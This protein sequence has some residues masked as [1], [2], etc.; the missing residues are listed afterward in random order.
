M[1]DERLERR[2]T[3]ARDGDGEAW[4]ALLAELQPYLRVLA[5]GQLD[6]G[7]RRR[8]DA[9]DVVQQTCLEAHRDL[10]AFRGTT[11]A[12]LAAWFRRILENNVAQVI[13]RHVVAQRRSVRR[14]RQVD[15]G[16]SRSGRGADAR[17]GSVTS[18]SQRAMRGEGAIE[19][20]RALGRLP[21]DQRD[22]VRLRHVEGWT[23]AEI[24]AWFDR[25]EAAVAALLKRGLLGLRE[26]LRPA[27]ASRFG[28]TPR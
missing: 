28:R 22:A 25:S 12:E 20:A 26:H 4:Q 13:Q 6:S 14:E 18:P 5:Q 3:D 21:E 9:T 1:A 24:A 19:L 27:H 15:P 17:E 23:L 2:L 7:L 10:E 11:R 16:S 8:V